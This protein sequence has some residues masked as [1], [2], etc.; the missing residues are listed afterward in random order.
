MSGLSLDGHVEEETYWAVSESCVGVSSLFP[1]PG[2]PQVVPTSDSF[3]AIFYSF[4]RR[5]LGA[6]PDSSNQTANTAPHIPLTYFGPVHLQV[7]RTASSEL[8]IELPGLYVV[9]F[10]GGGPHVSGGGGAETACP[11]VFTVEKVRGYWL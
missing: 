2:P 8:D 3:E 4:F 1:Q 6:I 11:V 10:S 7:P 5:A 9:P